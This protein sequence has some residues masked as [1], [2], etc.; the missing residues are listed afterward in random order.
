MK[1]E[2]FVRA[3]CLDCHFKR[4]SCGIAKEQFTDNSGFAVIQ[5]LYKTNHRMKLIHG[6]NTQIYRYAMGVLIGKTEG[7]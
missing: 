3:E 4:V 1:P 6:K 2:Y 7:D 5:H